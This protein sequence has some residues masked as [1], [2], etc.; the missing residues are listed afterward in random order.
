VIS[1]QEK[2]LKD[3]LQVPQKQPRDYWLA[4]TKTEEH[5]TWKMKLVR[6]NKQAVFILFYFYFLFFLGGV[7]LRFFEFYEYF[8]M[9]S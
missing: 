1:S 6:A 2:F 8:S 7:G 4:S 3:P 9:S 5:G